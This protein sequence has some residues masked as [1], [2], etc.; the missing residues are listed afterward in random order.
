MR[1]SRWW[2]AMPVRKLSWLCL[3]WTCIGLGAIG[4]FLP[5]LPTTPF[6]LVAAW[7]APKGSPRLATWLHSHPTFGPLLNAWHHQRAVPLRAKVIA[8]VMMTASWATL[9]LTDSAPFVLIATGAL[10]LV[11]GAF[12]FSRPTPKA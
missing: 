4:A 6:I 3:A 2:T 12:L 11:V 8:G 1:R 10:F 7:A 9:W 5:L